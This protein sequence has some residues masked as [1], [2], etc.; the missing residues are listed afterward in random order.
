MNPT[1]RKTLRWSLFAVVIATIG[2]IIWHTTR[3]VPVEIV[4]RP[5][6]TGQVEKIVANTRA[7]TVEACRR[8]KLS[9]SIGGQ[10]ARLPV[11]EGDSVTAGQL[12]LELWNDD[13]VAQTALAESEVTSAESRAKSAC[14]QAEVAQREADRQIKLRRSGSASE[15]QAD[16]TITRAQSLQAECKATRAAVETSRARVG[17][18][19]ANLDRTRLTAPFNGIIAQ[20]NGELSEFVT[21]SPIGIPTPPAVDIVDVS[22]FYVTAPI[23]EVD[24]AV[25]DTGLPA[26]ISLDAFGDRHFSGRVRRIAPFV[27]DREK[28]ARTVDIEVIF[29]NPDDMAE[30]LPGY[31]ADAEVILRTRDNVLHVPTEAVIDKQQVYVFDPDSKLLEMRNVTTGLA[32][33]EQTEIVSGVSEGEQVV[34][35]VDRK[36]I[37]DGATAALEKP[38]TQ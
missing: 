14:L 7:G 29:E 34:T 4:I 3:P 19:K 18:A 5:V 9:P 22:C 24:A 26:S 20:I 25:I 36:G 17:V 10:I 21:P 6:E 31:S 11:K 28:Q 15:E 32:N 38:E 37:T 33:W 23:D 2:V 1:L 16:K 27:L 30:M 13:L 12:L 35:T 8:A